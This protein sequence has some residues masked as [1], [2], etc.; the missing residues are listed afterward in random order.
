MNTDQFWSI[1]AESRKRAANT[2]LPADTEFFTL[3]IAE[4]KQL[5]VGLSPAD[6]IAYQGHFRSYLQL[7]Y[8]WDLWGAAYWVGGGCSDDSFWDFRACLISLG[9]ENFFQVLNDPD[10]L[11]DLVDRPDVP[12]MLSE[13]F[14]Y[15]AP[16]V[17]QELTGE[18]LTLAADQQSL[19]DEPEGE[20]FDFE[21]E[22]VMGQRY[23]RLV[24]RFPEMGD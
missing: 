16:E 1:I 2:P 11:A 21:D 14:Q 23:P 6:I 7:A 18:E 9:V 4:L 3:H 15:V 10:T 24:A 22:N 17:Y 8:R 5:L 19:P 12:Y 13:G 20:A